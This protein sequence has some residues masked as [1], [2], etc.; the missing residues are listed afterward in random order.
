MPE[1]LWTSC[2]FRLHNPHDTF[3]F[4]TVFL[5]RCV[6]KQAVWDGSREL[7]QRIVVSQRLLSSPGLSVRVVTEDVGAPTDWCFRNPHH[8]VV[9]HL[10]GQ[11]QRMESVFSVGPST[12]VLPAVGDTW[13]IP[14]GCQYAALAQGD[15]VS[16]AEFSIPA[17]LTRTDRPLARVGHR[18]AFLHQASARLAAVS[19]RTDDLGVMM[20][21]ALLDTLR[22][23]LIDALLCAEPKAPARV[24]PPPPVHAFS[25]RQKRLLTDHI[26]AH[27][28]GDITVERLA[29][30]SGLSMARFLSSFKASFGTTPWQYVLRF[31]LAQGQRL[32]KNSSASVTAIAS[33][34]GFSSPSHF[35]TAFSRHVGVSPAHYRITRA[36]DPDG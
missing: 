13:L 22:V 35:A 10:A 11:L 24:R 12:D 7:S 30:V 25:A 3:R 33:A 34:V 19:Q 9:V 14:A 8:M 31:R 26:H 29:A 15:S 2:A 1:M 27:V 6:G 17:D 36:A 18:D 32:L 23:H 16:F 20:Q 28:A 21:Q 4:N 5:G